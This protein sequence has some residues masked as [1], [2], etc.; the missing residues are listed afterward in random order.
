ML[1]LKAVDPIGFI[2]RG[3]YQPVRYYSLL[4]C[5]PDQEKW[6]SSNDVKSTVHSLKIN[7]EVTMKEQETQFSHDY[8]AKSNHAT[9]KLIHIWEI[10]ALLELI[11]SGWKSIF[12]DLLFMEHQELCNPSLW[13]VVRNMLLYILSNHICFVIKP[14][15]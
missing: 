15:L 7:F 11:T 5:R 6:L 2:K 10:T 1:C 13:D 8:H 3:P 4:Q 14:I 9:L 12:Y